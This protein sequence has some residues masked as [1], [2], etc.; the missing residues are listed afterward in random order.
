MVYILVATVAH[1]HAD[2]GDKTPKVKTMNFSCNSIIDCG[3]L[4][5]VCLDYCNRKD[6]F[7]W[8]Y[9]VDFDPEKDIS[10][11]SQLCSMTSLR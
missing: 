1:R 6:A 3:P 10:F 5:T 8:W 2:N 11:Q 9:L 7:F 4:R